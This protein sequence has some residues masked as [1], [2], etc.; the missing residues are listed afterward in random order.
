M[1]QQPEQLLRSSAAM[2]ALA[3]CLIPVV[4]ACTST[5]TVPGG[6]LRNGIVHDHAGDEVRIDPNS[7]V[8]FERSDGAWTDWY[9]ASELLVNDDGVFFREGDGLR[10]ADV[11]SSEVKNLSGGKTLVGVVAVSALV[12]GLVA[13]ALVARKAPGLPWKLGD[14]AARGTAHATVHVVARLP[15]SSGG[16]YAPSSTSDEP[17]QLSGSSGYELPSPTDAHGLFDGSERRRASVRVGASLD[18]GAAFGRKNEWSASV[19]PMLRLT[20]LFEIGGGM[21]LI[22]DDRVWLARVGL[23]AELDARR[24]FAL[25]FSI[26]LGGGSTVAFHARLNFGLRVQVLEGLWLGLNPLNPTYTRLRDPIGAMPHWSFP[27]TLETSF[28]F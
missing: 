1:P 2:R 9:A 11:R 27:T 28:A 8:R 21:R 24:M 5:S 19:V 26:D 6:V 4:A 12:V 20:D 22:R 13:V 14:A 16:G 3:V 10:W 15:V 23:H 25:P 17:S 18:Y 7:E